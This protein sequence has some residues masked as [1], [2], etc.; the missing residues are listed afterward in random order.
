LVAVGGEDVFVEV[1]ADE[2]LV[3]VGVTGVFVGVFVDPE[4]VGVD[5]RVPPGVNV[6]VG[7]P[8][9]GVVVIVSVP[10]GVRLYREVG[11]EVGPKEAWHL[12]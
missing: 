1:G 6:K 12:S 8:E 3:G 11:V 9:G 4:L 7:V 2:V 5:V 10:V